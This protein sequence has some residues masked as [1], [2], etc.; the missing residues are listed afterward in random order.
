MKG[1]ECFFK[2]GFGHDEV[3][4]IEALWHLN[5][6]KFS[7]DYIHSP[8]E[9]WEKLE[10]NREGLIYYP[11]YERTYFVQNLLNQSEGYLTNKEFGGFLSMMIINALCWSHE[12]QEVCS[13]LCDLYYETRELVLDN[14]S[15]ASLIKL[16]D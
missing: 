8:L 1:F 10:L 12:G 3:Q 6:I 5:A 13:K 11:T 2:M 7:K 15:N 14:F 4:R 16:L 9:K